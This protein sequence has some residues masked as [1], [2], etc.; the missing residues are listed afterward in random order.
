M[1]FGLS[2][3]FDRLLKFSIEYS[4]LKIKCVEFRVC[5][6]GHTKNYN[7]LYGV[8]S[9]MVHFIDVKMVQT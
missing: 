1:Y 8:K 5:L 3:K 9:F 2:C 7:M 4:L 6:H